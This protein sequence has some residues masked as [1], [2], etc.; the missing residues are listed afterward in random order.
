MPR[1][2][3]TTPA[4]KQAETALETRLRHLSTLLGKLSPVPDTWLGSEKK[5]DSGRNI[6]LT[7]LECTRYSDLI[8]AWRKALKWRQELDDVLSVMLSV[9][10]STEQIGDQLFLMVIGDAGSGKTRFCDG[11]LVSNRCYAMEHL[12]GFHSGWKDE[13]GEDFSLLARANRKTWITP[14]GDVMMSSP[15]FQQIMS[16]QRRIF[17]GTSGASFKNMKEDRRYTGLRTPWIIAGTPALMDTDQARLGDRFLKVIIDQPPEDEKREILRRVSHS[18]LRA[19]RQ[20]SDGTPESQVEERLGEA[21]RMTGG[22]IDWLTD[23][24][25]LLANVSVADEYL[26]ECARLAELTA[27]VR[28]RPS[29]NKEEQHDTKEMPTRLTHQY[30][31]LMACMTVVL[32][33]ES[34][35]EEVM[36]RVRKVALDTASG[37]VLKA[38]RHMADHQESGVEVR[39]LSAATGRRD[40]QV[41]TMLRFLGTIGAVEMFNPPKAPGEKSLTPKYRYRL[42]PKLY[43]LCL[44]VFPPAESRSS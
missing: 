30:V 41:R 17:D 29:R 40:D 32:N 5:E 3:K 37:Y 43:Q 39:G 22:Y 14:E 23:N 24:L 33:K 1:I 35:D 2:A 16:Q 38:V 26:D 42:S 19:V 8:N 20:R 28:A 13:T 11:M 44:E 15:H 36:R 7:P 18:A 12:T 21:Y 34:V 9:A 27:F 10:L 6:G 25:D 31:R 4:P